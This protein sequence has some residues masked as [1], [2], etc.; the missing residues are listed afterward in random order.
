MD[1][2]NLGWSWWRAIEEN[3]VDEVIQLIKKGADVNFNFG[4]R[5]WKHGTVSY[6]NT[7]PFDIAVMLGHAEIAKLLLDAGAFI[8]PND[9]YATH[10]YVHSDYKL[11]NS[12]YTSG[13]NSA[14]W[15][16]SYTIKLEEDIEKEQ[17]DIEKIRE[18]IDEAMKEQQ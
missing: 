2:N 7:T 3:N 12:T 11:L 1:I 9:Y 8:K 13:P 16:A 14:S 15:S 5:T 4:T 17:E 18:M 6:D 10:G